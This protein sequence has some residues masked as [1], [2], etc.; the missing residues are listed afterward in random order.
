MGRKAIHTE[1]APAAVGPYSQAVLDEDSGYL[2]C[3]GQI[4]LDPKT[5]TL[6]AGGV[7]TEFRRVL[8][9]V[10]AVLRAVDLDF[11][12]VVK[13]TLFL[14]DMGDF[15]A[16]NAIYAESFREPFPA[17]STVAALGLPKGARVELEVIAR[18]RRR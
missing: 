10:R 8:E 15:G 12:D 2:F 7:E 4:G 1:E 14:A 13:S 18:L 9:N 6:V 3:S 5:Q 11:S 17:R 16:V